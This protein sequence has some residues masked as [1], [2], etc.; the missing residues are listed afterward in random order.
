MDDGPGRLRDVAEQGDRA[1]ARAP[2]DG[3]K[4]HG[5]QIL[6]LVDDHVAEGARRLAEE[7]ACLV[8]EGDVAFAPAEAGARTAEQA[9]L[10]LVED[11]LGRGRER[12]AL[13]EEASDERLRADDGP[14]AVEPAAEEALRLERALHLA[15]V[16]PGQ[17][18]EARAVVLVEAAQDAHPEALARLRRE[19]ELP[20]HPVDE[21]GHLPLADPDVLAFEP[22]D[23]LLRARGRARGGSAGD[24]LRDAKVA[25]QSRGLRSVGRPS[26][27]ARRPARSPRA[28][29]RAPRRA[30]GGRG[31]RTP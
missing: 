4:L 14:D 7:R 26:R 6:R 13:R 21:R 8:D 10:R 20:A 29:R 23:E 17:P 16:P 9:L 22:D 31:R 24:H 15:E 18:A 12:G 30:T 11:A 5:R 1:A 2:R 28:A 19:T 3:A 27:R 25:L